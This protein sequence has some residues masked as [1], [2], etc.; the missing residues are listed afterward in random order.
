MSA[1]LNTSASE[2]NV[3]A[4]YGYSVREFIS[5]PRVVV[6]DDYKSC[7]MLVHHQDVILPNRI[8]NYRNH[9]T[10]FRGKDS[11]LVVRTET[12][13]LYNDN[14]AVLTYETIRVSDEHANRM[15]ASTGG[16]DVSFDRDIC[17]SNKRPANFTDYELVGSGE[18]WYFDKGVIL[19][20]VT[21][22][23]ENLNCVSLFV[24]YE[25]HPK[26]MLRRVTKPAV[27][28]V[29]AQPTAST[30]AAA[31]ATT[32]PNFLYS[33]SDVVGGGGGGG[34][35]DNGDGVGGGGDDASGRNIR[36]DADAS[37]GEKLTSLQS[38]GLPTLDPQT[39]VSLVNV[40]SRSMICANEQVQA[41]NV[42]YQSVVP[43][44]FWL[45]TR[46]SELRL[47]NISYFLPQDYKCAYGPLTTT[48]A[49]SMML[50][51]PPAT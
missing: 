31:T 19:N 20:G 41:P 35:G 32:L 46:D 11:I 29:A 3:C 5:Q 7:F 45:K 25:L 39:M 10:L 18:W 14:D 4:E 12:T 30:A 42:E 13:L 51:P 24:Y 40:S 2:I 44:L 37:I 15:R 38:F 17:F 21:K 28:A 43:S 1:L 8:A 47:R 22:Y 6:C 33:R 26:F 49:S 34:N 48:T 9:F 27:R 36:N 16:W 50:P 23:V